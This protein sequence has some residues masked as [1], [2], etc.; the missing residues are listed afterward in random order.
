MCEYLISEAILS[1][2]VGDFI[3]ALVQMYYLFLNGII[4]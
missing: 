4:Y 1:S 3:H 2:S